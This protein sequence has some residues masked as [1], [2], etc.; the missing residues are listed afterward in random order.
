MDFIFRSLLH[1]LRGLQSVAINVANNDRTLKAKPYIQASTLLSAKIKK[2]RN[3]LI[4]GAL[5]DFLKAFVKSFV[6]VL[7]GERG[8]RTPGSLHYNGFQDRRIRPLC[9]LSIAGA[10]IMEKYKFTKKSCSI[11]QNKNQLFICRLKI[12][13]YFCIC[14]LGM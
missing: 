9:H 6:F 2:H 4:Y 12:K 11:L 7:C 8:I 3:Q 10:K 1:F 14:I 5:N 13:H